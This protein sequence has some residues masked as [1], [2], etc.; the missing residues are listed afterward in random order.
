M[1]TRTCTRKNFRIST[2]VPLLSGICS[3]NQKKILP[4]KIT[5][6]NYENLFWLILYRDLK[7]LGLFCVSEKKYIMAAKMDTPKIL[8][9]IDKNQLSLFIKSS[10]TAFFRFFCTGMCGNYSK[11][12]LFFLNCVCA[13][14]GTSGPRVFTAALW[15]VKR[16][17]G[18]GH[19]SR[20]FSFSV[21]M[22]KHF[23]RGYFISFHMQDNSIWI[24]TM[25]QFGTI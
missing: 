17:N 23:G 15:K 24:D 16:G 19:I 6:L 18:K 2:F 12:D 7:S 10:W 25:S 14:R 20:K 21:N 1:L 11:I 13:K 3:K 9:K 5:F 4:I 22:H 8:G